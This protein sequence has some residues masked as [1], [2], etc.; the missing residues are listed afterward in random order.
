[1]KTIIAG[2]RNITDYNIVVEAVYASKF[3]ITGI[4]SG[5]ARGVDQLGE[6]Y[7]KEHN[8]KI[9]E[10]PADWDKFGKSAGY[11]RNKEMAKYADVL[12]AI[13][14][15]KSK[16]T[17]HMIDLGHKHLLEVFVYQINALF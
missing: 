15:G 4:V 11:I 3:D 9:H 12:I 2:S 13:W 16:G 8:L 5:R 10:F 7:A 1:M 14:D 17:K 6:Q